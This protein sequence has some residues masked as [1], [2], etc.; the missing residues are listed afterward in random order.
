[1][2]IELQKT[3]ET[4][5]EKD[6]K[7]ELFSEVDLKAFTDLIKDK[8]DFNELVKWLENEKTITEIQGIK[9]LKETVESFVKTKWEL[10]NLKSLDQTYDPLAKNQD[11]YEACVL[12]AILTKGKGVKADYQKLAKEYYLTIN[13]TKVEK[14]ETKPN[15]IGNYESAKADMKNETKTTIETT[16]KIEAGKKTT[17]ASINISAGA[18]MRSMKIENAKNI[19]NEKINGLKE[20]QK[21]FTDPNKTTIENIINELA[22]NNIEKNIAEKSGKEQIGNRYLIGARI[23]EGFVKVLEDIALIDPKPTLKL[24]IDWKNCIIGDKN[25]D[26]EK[27]RFINIS[28][29]VTKVANTPGEKQQI[30]NQAVVPTIETGNTNTWTKKII[31]VGKTTGT[32]TSTGTIS[33]TNGTQTGSTNQT[34]TNSWAD[35][36][37]EKPTTNE[38]RKQPE[39]TD[40][41]TKPWKGGPNSNNTIEK[42]ESSE[43]ILFKWDVAD[44]FTFQGKVFWA[45]DVSDVEQSTTN[46]K[47]YKVSIKWY[48]D[49]IVSYVWENI[50]I[51]KWI[52]K[53]WLL[54]RNIKEGQTVKIDRK[55]K[56]RSKIKKDVS[57]EFNPTESK[58]YINEKLKTTTSG[59]QWAYEVKNDADVTES[60]IKVEYTNPKIL[61]PANPGEKVIDN[62]TIGLDSEYL[63]NK[64]KNN[65]VPSERQKIAGETEKINCNKPYKIKDN[66]TKLTYY[67]KT[68]GGTKDPTI[69][70]INN[71]TKIEENKTNGNVA[72]IP[73]FKELTIITEKDRTVEKYTEKVMLAYDTPGITSVE[74]NFKNTASVEYSDQKYSINTTFTLPGKKEPLVVK[75][76]ITYTKWSETNQNTSSVTY[77]NTPILSWTDEY[78]KIENGNLM[79]DGIVYYIGV[80]NQ[81][82]KNIPTIIFRHIE[83][84]T[85]SKAK[86]RTKDYKIE[87]NI[88]GV[89]TV[90]DDIQSYKKVNAGFGNCEYGP[91][92]VKE[93]NRSDPITYYK[94]VFVGQVKEGNRVL[95]EWTKIGTMYFS[96]HGKFL[97][98]KTNDQQMTFTNQTDKVDLVEN[99]PIGLKEP[100]GKTGKNILL[101]QSMQDKT[102]KVNIM[103]PE[104][105]YTGKKTGTEFVTGQDQEK[106]KNVDEHFYTSGETKLMIAEN[107]IAMYEG[108]KKISSDD[109]NEKNGNIFNFVT[110]NK[111]NPNVILGPDRRWIFAYQLIK[112]YEWYPAQYIYCKVDNKKISLCNADGAVLDQQK[113]FLKSNNDYYKIKLDETK[114]EFK[115]IGKEKEKQLM[116]P[117]VETETDSD[118]KA[119]AWDITQE[120]YCGYRASKWEN[121]DSYQFMCDKYTSFAVDVKKDNKI[122]GKDKIKDLENFWLVD[123]NEEGFGSYKDFFMTEKQKT[124]G[125]DEKTYKE[126]FNKVLKE[127]E[128]KTDNLIRVKYKKDGKFYYAP[129]YVD[130]SKKWEKNIFTLSQSKWWQEAIKETEKR[131]DNLGKAYSIFLEQDITTKAKGDIMQWWYMVKPTIENTNNYLKD[132]AKNI[133]IFIK[134]NNKINDKFQE[135]KITFNPEKETIDPT[136]ITVNSVKY[137]IKLERDK[138]IGYKIIFKKDDVESAGQ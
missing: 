38:Q 62:I 86:E 4:A 14:N 19:Y 109:V 128:T 108:L 57:I 114:T 41:I 133:D 56:D 107:R 17:E 112:P 69:N 16:T 119:Y 131:L 113:I 122:E 45:Q 59:D 58:K 20:T 116:M 48:T 73:L 21:K 94:E 136:K 101:T 49:F 130:I 111:T 44:H 15:I 40:I 138:N 66:I 30:K 71:I 97:E 83:D 34:N 50:E 33:Q 55:E 103:N 134:T 52:V 120:R 74:K 53:K 13:P 117:K 61:K 91:L 123:E 8:D 23:A 96:Q 67:A 5:N 37:N 77:N 137:I 35:K 105:T 7:K 43:I 110:E 63:M 79:I 22:G 125:I 106:W 78:N 81:Q 100:L 3:L 88:F 118:Y 36:T 47:Q 102:L 51:T 24:S 90:D 64:G 70:I 46:P 82:Q 9:G 135:Q 27:D 85:L 87:S 132:P 6:T 98:Y 2:A 32:G 26:I 28:L 124:F 89:K 92:T 65:N 68:S 11:L 84:K 127:K 42:K 76:P 54:K 39:W 29:Q 115:I 25:Q 129:M 80:A 72:D 95:L 60:T 75:L 121:D 18:D 99:T 104:D 1:M 31:V 93:G 12:G 126:V 10:E